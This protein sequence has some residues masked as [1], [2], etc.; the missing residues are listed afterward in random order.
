M[1]AS[2]IHTCI[3]YIYT[4][5]HA[6]SHETHI[7]PPHTHPNTH[8]HTHTHLATRE[9]DG[10]LPVIALVVLVVQQQSG[11]EDTPV[12]TATTRKRS[13]M[14]TYAHKLTQMSSQTNKETDSNDTEG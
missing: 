5:L 4:C 1:H 7:H 2:Y 12:V 10:A 6:D 3:T 9:Q 8:P 13:G 11:P 14:Q